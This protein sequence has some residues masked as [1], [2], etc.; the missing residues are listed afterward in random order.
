MNYQ[1]EVVEGLPSYLLDL[2]VNIC[3]KNRI[4][5]KTKGLHCRV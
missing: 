1:A 5:F 4:S 3:N 2:Y